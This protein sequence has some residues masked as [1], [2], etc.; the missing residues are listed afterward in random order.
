MTAATLLLPTIKQTKELKAL[1]DAAGR[2]HHT[3]EHVSSMLAMMFG[4]YELIHDKQAL[5][6]AI[7]YHDAIYEPGRDDNE[8]LSAAKMIVE[9]PDPLGESAQFAKQLILA[10]ERH[11]VPPGFEGERRRDCEHF[12]DLD[13]AILGAAPDLYLRYVANIRV[14]YAHIEEEQFA[15]GRWNFLNELTSR[16]HIFLSD[17]FRQRFETRARL[18]IFDE[19]NSLLKPKR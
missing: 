8:R 18:N 5:I 3:W 15:W 1:Y 2:H 10:T 6:W 19:K 9:H 4:A 7:Y 12:L 11:E 14:E 13:M 16:K 17:H